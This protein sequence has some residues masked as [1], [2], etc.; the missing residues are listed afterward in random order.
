MSSPETWF[1]DNG[2]QFRCT[3]CGECCKQPGFVYLTR[4]E[5][6]RIARHL[7]DDDASAL[8][9]TGEYWTEQNDGD[10]VIEVIAGRGCP[11]LVDNAC[12]VQPVK[13]AQCRTY[14]FWP[15]N[16]TSPKR[17]RAEMKYCEG[18]GPAGDQYSYVDIL[19]LLEERSATREND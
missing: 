17:W 6:D 3:G 13:P 4:E 2:L 11:F 12:S 7:L 9:L 19:S 5:G 10:F 15:E 1:K 14:P 18:I 8:S 16:L